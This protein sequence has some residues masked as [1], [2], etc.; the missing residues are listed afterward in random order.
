M[1]NI[2]A[3]I[4][5]TSLEPG[6]HLC[7]LYQGDEDCKTWANVSLH[8]ALIHNETILFVLDTPETENTF[9]RCW[10]SLPAVQT[11]RERGQ[12]QT[13][14]LHQSQDWGSRWEAPESILDGLRCES[15]SMRSQGYS[16]LRVVFDMTSAV[17]LA[18][19]EIQI[20]QYE[21]HLDPL[22]SQQPF[23]WVCTYD[24]QQLEAE[25]LLNLV[26]HHRQLG[27]NGCIFENFYYIPTEEW[28]S[29]SHPESAL[30]NWFSNLSA[31]RTAQQKLWEAS[32]RDPLTGFFNKAFFDSELNTIEQ[33]APCTFSLV[34]VLVDHPETTLEGFDPRVAQ[35]YL[36]RAADVL[37]SSSR[38]TDVIA[39]LDERQFAVLVPGGEPGAMEATVQRIRTALH[40]HNHER[41]RMPLNLFL[42]GATSRSGCSN[43]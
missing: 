11:A 15:E 29:A 17:R 18:Q 19:S 38:D 12:V 34:M 25:L 6:D 16:L 30:Q 42:W 13:L 22:I 20:I 9:E 8:Q 31:Y 24:R 1:R 4:D 33:T 39:R 40:T 10:G 37:K 23:A 14:P 32:M 41:Q 3:N 36:R 35:E 43:N 27:I 2:Y 28:F 21:T 26:A 7:L 5:Q